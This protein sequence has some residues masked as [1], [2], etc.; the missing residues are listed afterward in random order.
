MKTCI[1]LYSYWKL[2]KEN[3]MNHYEVMDEI[4]RLGVDAVEFQ[5]FDASVPAGKTMAD[6]IRDLHSYARKIGLAV[7]MLTL[8]ANLYNPKAEEELARLCGLA[9]VASECGIRFLR[10]DV[11]YGFLG[12]EACPSYKKVI[13]SVTP[14]IRR[15]AYYAQGQGVMVCSENHGRLLQ[16]SYRIEELFTAVNHENYKLLCDIGNFSDADE[17][18]FSAVSRLLPHI[19]FVHAKD[20]FLRSGMMYDPGK[21]YYRTRGGDFIRSTIFGHGNVPT[22]QILW[23]IKNSGYDG[24]ISL[25]F[26]GVEEPKMAVEIS[27]ENMKR[28]LADLEK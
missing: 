26:E 9:D 27:I 6:Y 25:E 10:F 20:F 28:M 19:C 12:N 11:T 22:Y 8:S 2:V 24:Y 7:P 14:Y 1:S 4:K 5:I 17:D 23:A 13:E 18:C 16:D 21:G 3:K 15:L